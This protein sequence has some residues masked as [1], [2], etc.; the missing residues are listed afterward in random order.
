MLQED[1]YTGDDDPGY[2]VY[3]I[4]E[5]EFKDVTRKIAEKYGYPESATAVGTKE[6]PGKVEEGG[7]LPS[8]VKFP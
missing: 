3:E 8:D 5:R 1:E 4:G 7:R 6:A 2:E